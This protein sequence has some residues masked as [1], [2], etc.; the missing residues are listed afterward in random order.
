MALDFT[1]NPGGLFP[2][3]GRILHLARLIDIYEATLPAAFNEILDQYETTLQNVAGP[4]AVGA[5]TLV[6]VASAAMAFAAGAEGVN[7]AAW[8]T[9][10]SMVLADQPSQSWTRKTAMAEVVRQMI[11]QAKTVLV[12]VI[13]CTPTQLT[14]SIGTGPIV[15]T[16]RRGDGFVQENTIAETLRV[17][18]TL[19]S[20]TGNATQGREQFS[21]V[22]APIVGG[23]WDYDYPTGSGTGVQTNAISTSQDASS[24]GNLTTNGNLA[25]WT[26]ATPALDN[27][28]LSVGAWGTDIQQ[29]TTTPYAGSFDLQ[30]NVSAL[31]TAIYQEFN[32]TAGSNVIPPALSSLV[33]NFPIMRTGVVSAGVLTVELVD[34]TGTVVND[35]QGVPNSFTVTLSAITTSYVHTNNVFRL[36]ANPPN[37]LRLRFRMSTALAG[38]SVRIGEIAFAPMVAMYTGGPSFQVFAGLVP[39]VGGDGWSIANTNDQGGSTFVSTF[40]TGFQRLFDMRAMG[41]LLPSD[42]APNILNTLI[43]T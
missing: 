8:D 22:G 28:T 34:S 41:L 32:N 23:V 10:V 3:L 38:A 31:N 21:L 39:F 37:V 12:N 26:G 2:R 6:R 7:N 29:N 9:V 5:N 19:D 27:W 15:V 1:T 43:T 4:V 11:A 40:Q 25:D 16:T 18:C 35:E 42:A 36:P 30:F 33:V 17:I 20:Y 13:S 24:T 14:G